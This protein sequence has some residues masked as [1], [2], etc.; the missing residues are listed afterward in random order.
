MDP[1]SMLLIRVSLLEKGGSRAPGCQMAR[2]DIA[3]DSPT[4]MGATFTFIENEVV[5]SG[6][7][8]G[9]QLKR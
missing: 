5:I 1:P 2:M 6:T 8:P 4:L 3:D 9:L 7:D